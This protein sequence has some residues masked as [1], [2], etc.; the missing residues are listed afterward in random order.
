[1][2]GDSG[3]EMDYM[4][5]V[6]GGVCE[7]CF[8]VLGGS[9]DVLTVEDLGLREREREGRIWLRRRRR[10]EEGMSMDWG[11]LSRE[12]GAFGLGWSSVEEKGVRSVVTGESV[13]CSAVIPK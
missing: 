5:K 1:V 3:C 4:V 7:A 2:A 13:A 9:V 12:K 6:L 8:C 11:E 10:F